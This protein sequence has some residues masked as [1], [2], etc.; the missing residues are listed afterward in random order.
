M[1]EQGID[2][3]ELGRDGFMEHAW[4]WKEKYGGTIVEQLKKLGASCD[5][6]RERFT[7]DEGCSDAVLDVF[8]KYYEKGYIYQGAKLINWCP[9][10]QTT[11]SEAEV[12]H[13]EKS[14][15]FWHIK[16]PRKDGNGFVEIATTRPETLLG[17]T[18]VAVHPDDERYADLV[19]KTVILPIVNREIPVIADTYVD[20]EFG[21]GC[22]K[23]TPAMTQMTLRWVKDTT[24]S[25]SML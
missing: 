3:D 5:W 22:V 17:D 12:E 6:E 18:A 15:H 16:Y 8:V 1:A 4:K 10:C 14:G 23:I 19:G 13:E 24:L 9:V 11:I 21:T 20:K 7:L 25:K 2:K